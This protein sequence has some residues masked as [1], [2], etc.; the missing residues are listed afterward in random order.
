[1]DRI[2][3]P[4]MNMTFNPQGTGFTGAKSFSGGKDARMKSFYS[5]AKFRAKDYM[6]GSYSGQG[7]WKGDF[8]YDT[9]NANTE[10]R[11]WAK[12]SVREHATKDA[13]VKESRDANRNYSTRQHA[14]ANRTSGFRG[15]SQDKIDIHG[16]QGALSIPGDTGFREL[17]TIDDIRNLLNKD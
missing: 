15:K 4:N 9:K 17:R 8:T 6:T 10:G 14:S 11:G 13:A 5:P 12:R 1:M 2:D 7:P 3:R 16:P